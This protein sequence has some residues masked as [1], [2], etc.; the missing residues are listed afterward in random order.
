MYSQSVNLQPLPN[1]D[2][3]QV[4]FSE[5]F[6]LAGC[7]NIRITTESLVQNTWVYLE[8]DLINEETGLKI[9]V[10]IEISYYYGVEDGE[11]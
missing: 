5:P 4:F 11:S 2:G 9:S 1:E 10:P 6:E 7:R 3:T 8:A